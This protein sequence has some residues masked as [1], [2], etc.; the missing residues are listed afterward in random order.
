MDAGVDQALLLSTSNAEPLGGSGTNQVPYGGITTPLTPGG[1]A[2]YTPK[3]L[4]FC[5]VLDNPFYQTPPCRG[6]KVEFMRQPATDAGGPGTFME[7]DDL[8]LLPKGHD[9]RRAP[10]NFEKVIEIILR[11]QNRGFQIQPAGMLISSSNRQAANLDQ[12]PDNE[13]QGYSLNH[14]ALLSSPDGDEMY[15]KLHAGRGILMK[16][17]EIQG[18]V[19]ST[20]P[21]SFGGGAPLP[22]SKEQEKKLDDSVKLF[23]DAYPEF[24]D[25]EDDEG[26]KLSLKPHGYVLDVPDKMR[27]ITRLVREAWQFGGCGIQIAEMKSKGILVRHFFPLHNV[28]YQDAYGLGH[29]ASLTQMFSA[30]P[31]YQVEEHVVKYF[32][33]SVGLYFVWIRKYSLFLRYV[34]FF[35][36]VAGILDILAQIHEPLREEMGLSVVNMVFSIICCVWGVAWIFKW[37][38]VENEFSIRYGQD[39]QVTQELV[40]DE[41]YQ[42]EAPKELAIDELY[43]MDFNYPLTLRNRQD[44]S[45]MQLYDN[46]TKRAF[47]RY[48]VS[49][50]LILILA[51]AMVTGL[52]YTTYWR[53][54]DPTNNVVS[55][56]SSVCTLLIGFVFGV[57]FDKI[58]GFVNNLENNRTDTE[59]EEQTINKSFLFYF[60][61]YYFAL[62]TIALWP[63]DIS[64]SDRLDQL[65]TQMLIIT[66]AKPMVQNIM[67]LFMPRLKAQLRIR[68]DMAGG[69]TIAGF[70]SLLR[71]EPMP[72]DPNLNEHDSE[73]RRLWLEAQMEPYESTSGDYLEI[74][75]QYGYMTMFA[76]TFPWAAVAA[77]LYNILEIRID[78]RK[79]LRECQRPVARPANTI[80]AWNGIFM[81]L[82]VL[83][84]ITNGYLIAIMSSA[85]SRM[86]LS[87]DPTTR[88]KVFTI[89][90][91]IFVFSFFVISIWFAGN[92]AIYNKTRAK[93]Q[94]LSNRSTRARLATRMRQKAS[95]VGSEPMV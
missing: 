78:A 66:V 95:S 10:T 92:S 7:D 25:L 33:E 63:S 81:L 84:V 2:K 35:G 54:R 34:A 17:A 61:S 43:R 28:H 59:Q 39:A 38:R 83:S 23:C 90:Q 89:A 46:S 44:G 6:M 5:L 86:G 51:G 73:G 14:A 45:M 9:V 16:F 94:I 57:L 1:E 82:S 64:D 69:S 36:L 72:E 32:G 49:Y 3:S 41:F 91:Y 12:I 42:A 70:C 65:A 76:A 27:L 18:V 93:F 22:F 26:N 40:R 8:L 71:C 37:R 19:L 75:L 24:A 50:P 31:F 60:F 20:H 30:H 11:L 77:L 58:V 56:A 74:T 55:Y 68:T 79:I 88:Y 47:M 80:G 62:F 67:E 21:Y 53:F 15:I 48:A 29:W 52:Y 85:P 13:F 87:V 4:F